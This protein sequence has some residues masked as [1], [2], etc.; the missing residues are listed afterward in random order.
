[1]G[2]K[3]EKKYAIRLG[4]LPI[5]R[6]KKLKSLKRDIAYIPAFQTGTYLRDLA[7]NDPNLAFSTGVFVTS[8]KR[9]SV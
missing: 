2:V 3:D 7:A 4:K 1:M 9:S 6:R 8:T 5:I